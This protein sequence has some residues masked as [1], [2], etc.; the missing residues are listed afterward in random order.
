[1]IDTATINKVILS[2]P[3]CKSGFLGAVPWNTIPDLGSGQSCIT[4]THCDLKPG[5]HWLTFIHINGKLEFFDSFGLA[6]EFY[7]GIPRIVD[8]NNNKQVQ[9][10][11]AVTCGLWAMYYLLKR[12]RGCSMSNIVAPFDEVNTNDIVLSKWFKKVY[13]LDVQPYY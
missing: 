9:H 4:N 13:S 10:F 6:P 5:E 2:D 3:I 1:M 12:Y 7:P 8:I 11:K